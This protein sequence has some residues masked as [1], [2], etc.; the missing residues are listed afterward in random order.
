MIGGLLRSKQCC[1]SG[2]VAPLSDVNWFRKEKANKNKVVRIVDQFSLGET[3]VNG[4][5]EIFSLSFFCRQRLDEFDEASNQVS[6]SRHS[7]YFLFIYLF[8]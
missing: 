6:L 4:T 7:S 8:F 2:I 1:F 5:H 3:F